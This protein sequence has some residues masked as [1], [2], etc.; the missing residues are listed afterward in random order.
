MLD[1]EK[2]SES[3]RRL[4]VALL[5]SGIIAGVTCLGGVAWAVISTDN[6]VPNNNYGPQCQWADVCKT[7]NEDVY[8]YM[9]QA[10]DDALEAAD[11]AMV[12]E[13]IDDEYRPTDLV[14]HYDSNP[15][16]SGSGETDW[17]YQ[18]QTVSGD[19]RGRTVCND[20]DWGTYKCDQHYITIEPGYWSHG[21]TCHE[22]GHAAGLL[23]GDKADP[24]VSMTDSVLGCMKTPVST[25]QVLGQNQENQINANY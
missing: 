1:V 5:A 20:P 15:T 19:S 2:S 7:D 4:R 16:F 13:V 17:Y 18:E 8:F 25:G 9:D 24:R 23:H 6:L 11:D 22:S 12:N 10:G 14:M 3:R 21:L